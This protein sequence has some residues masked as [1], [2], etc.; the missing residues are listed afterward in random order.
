MTDNSV[1]EKWTEYY[2]EDQLKTL[3]DI[4]LLI[5]DE[6]TRICQILNIDFFLYGG[7]LIGAV[8]YHG[9]VPWDDDIDIALPRDEYK[10]LVELGPG[11]ASEAFYFQTPY[12]DK[13]C[14]FSYSKL[15][16]KGTKYVEY[17][18]HKLSIEQGIYVDIYPIDNLPDDDREYKKQ[19]R[20]FQFWAKLYARRQCPYT[21]EKGIGLKVT[22][23]KAIKLPVS[24]L[25]KAIP[26]ERLIRRIDRISSEYNMCLTMRAGNYYHATPV[27]VFKS[28]KP[29]VI[30]SYENREMKLPNDW[31]G[32]LTARYGDYRSLPPESKRIGHKP[33]V[34]DFGGYD[35]RI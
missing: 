18:Y 35:T 29:Y 17:G 14:P 1:E 20:K 11:I 21:T 19:Y 10:K 12:N 26:A 8:K 4:E 3:Q 32:F 13:K 27:N 24:Y 2:T 6:I 9:F 30:G 34:L 23:K 31:E 22:L 5:L 28:I 33:Y 16:L 15:R 7:S 25:L